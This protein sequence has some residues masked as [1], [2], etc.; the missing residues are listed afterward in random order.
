[1]LKEP[2]QTGELDLR[3]SHYGATDAR[4]R[5][6]SPREVD[7]A[8]HVICSNTS[9]H[10]SHMQHAMICKLTMQNAIRKTRKQLAV[11]T[12]ER[13]KWST[14]CSVAPCLYC[15]WPC[16]SLGW[17][18]RPPWSSCWEEP[19]AWRTCFPSGGGD[20]DGRP[21]RPVAKPVPAD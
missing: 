2:E 13:S 1:M 17:C 6:G 11:K 19:C 16:G 9:Y 10:E 7:K 8:G 5:A 21:R 15:P 12:Y 14:C 4:T 20:D 18:P 3:R